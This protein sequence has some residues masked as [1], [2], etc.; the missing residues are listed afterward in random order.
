MRPYGLMADLHLHAW[1]AFSTVTPEGVNSR[2]KGLLSEIVRCAEEVRGHGGDTIVMA[3]DVF[4]VR[5]SVSP[6]VLNPTLDTLKGLTSSGIRVIAL[7]GNHD[8]EGKN[9]TRLGSAITALEGV[10]VHVVNKTEAIDHMLC[11]PWVEHIDDLKGLLALFNKDETKG[12]DLI[13]HAPI[14]GVLMGIPNHGLAPEYLADL[15]FDRVFSGHYHHHKE[16]SGKVYSIGALA[17]HTWSDVNSKAGFLI[18]GDGFVEWRQSRLPE[19]IDITGDM[20]WEEARLLVDGNFARAKVTT[21]K[22]SDVESLREALLAEGAQGVI[23]QTIKTAKVERTGAVAASVKAGAS[24]EASISEWV[25]AQSFP[26]A[27]QIERECQLVL[28]EAGV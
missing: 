10:G 28:A 14:D 16:F 8:L 11:V 23:I 3:G 13:M 12:Y 20:D 6:S 4:H 18:V 27:A 26:D 19:F 22:M 5:G 1:S 15:G 21:S 17:H 9:S 25:K 2:L 7:A 24:I